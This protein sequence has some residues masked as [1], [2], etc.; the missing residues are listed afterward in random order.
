MG[1]CRATRY[2]GL[3]RLLP[4]TFRLPARDR[5][6]HGNRLLDHLRE[7]ESLAATQSQA[8]RPPIGSLLAFRSDPELQL[9]LKSLESER[10]GIE[11]RC[12]REVRNVTEAVVYV[13]QGKLAYFAQKVQAYLTRDNTDREGNPTTPRNDRFVRSIADISLAALEKLWTDQEPMPAAD[14]TLW[15]EVWID[16]E[17]DR[18]NLFRQ[19]ASAVGLTLGDKTLRFPDREVLLAYGSL[20]Q[21]KQSLLRDLLQA[22]LG[23]GEAFWANHADSFQRVRKVVGRVKD[24]L[25]SLDEINRPTVLEVLAEAPRS[26]TE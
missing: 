5:V 24:L 20:E 7:A 10:Q 13:P 16:A 11:L 3:P 4:G 21:F 2:G 1:A 8:A 6:E 18:L 17:H 14:Q 26:L 19:E 9:A 15:W 25:P 23:A 12:V 22:V